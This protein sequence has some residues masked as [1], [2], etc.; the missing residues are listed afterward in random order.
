[1]CERSIPAKRSQLFL[2]NTLIHARNGAHSLPESQGWLG[3]IWWLCLGDGLVEQY[4]S[5]LAE[6]SSSH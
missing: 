6:A 2:S 4:A 3:F 5:A 1:M